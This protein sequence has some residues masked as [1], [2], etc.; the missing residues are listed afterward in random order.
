[1]AISELNRLASS[2]QELCAK[3]PIEEKWLIAQSRRIGQQ[4][5]DAVAR[6]GQSVLNARIK[7]IA[8]MAVDLASPEMERTGVSF[9][10]SVEA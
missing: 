4:W 9:L 8:S 5:L 10:Q 7:T 2:L 6:S 1:M 3:H